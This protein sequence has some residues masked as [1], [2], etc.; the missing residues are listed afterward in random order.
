MYDDMLEKEIISKLIGIFD[1]VKDTP[2]VYLTSTERREI[3]LWLED[4]LLEVN[5]EEK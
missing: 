3:E 5:K 4:K 1:I 2:L